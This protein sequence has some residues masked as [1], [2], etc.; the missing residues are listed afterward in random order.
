[1]KRG[2]ESRAQRKAERS[3]KGWEGGWG[4]LSPST[5]QVISTLIEH[6]GKKM[7]NINKSSFFN[8]ISHLFIHLHYSYTNSIP[9]H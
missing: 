9:K 2:E 7:E 1:M 3:G 5:T 8:P 6:K 4:G